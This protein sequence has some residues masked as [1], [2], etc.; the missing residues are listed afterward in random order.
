MLPK[1]DFY[2]CDEFAVCAARTYYSAALLLSNSRFVVDDLSELHTIVHLLDKALQHAPDFLDAHYLRQEIWHK[3]LKSVKPTSGNLEYQRYLQSPAWIVK[4]GQVLERDGHRCA[5]CNA[6]ATDVH[7]KTYENIGKEPFTDL[8][9]LCRSC[10]Q[11]YENDKQQLSLENP[12]FRHTG[13][14]TLP[15][16]IPPVP[17]PPAPEE[18]NP[19]DEE[20]D[21]PF[22][23]P[24][25]VIPI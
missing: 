17:P 20:R 10:H 24:T 1:T 16:A 6:N 22:D 11:R 18:P 15:P 13:D 4:K 8:T 3:I 19:N 14:T 23:P 12:P 21:V 5:F 2:D 9:S 7:H 25:T